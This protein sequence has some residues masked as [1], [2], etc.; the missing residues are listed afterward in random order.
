MTERLVLIL[1]LT[2]L[3]ALSPGCSG[4]MMPEH[5]DAPRAV[6]LSMPVGG[7][8]LSSADPGVFADKEDAFR[9]SAFLSD[10]DGEPSDWTATTTAQEFE[11]EP[12]D[13]VGGIPRCRVP[14]YY[15]P[16]TVGK[17]LWFY[18]YAPAAGGTYNRG[19]GAFAPT[20]SYTLTGQEDIMAAEVTGNGIAGAPYGAP[21]PQP[22]FR[23]RHLLTRLTFRLVM[24]EGFASDI[25]AS[26]IGIACC[27]NKAT[28]DIATGTLTFEG[29]PTATL[30]VKGTWAV[31]PDGEALELPNVSLMCEPGRE[32][33]VEAVVAGVTYR[34]PV[35]LGGSD[36]GTAAAGVSYLLT[37][38][39]KGTKVEAS[40][41]IVPWD[42]VGGASGEIK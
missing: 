6:S 18:A 37:L 40:G 21:Q 24:G 35:T 4:D 15:P 13:I 8:S 19:S 33:T 12:V 29:E 28:L 36:T 26:A 22:S 34:A 27:R 5:D 20:V 11:N 9:L 31:K 16:S 25:N 41:S 23:F 1:T 10:S 39:F 38:T 7:N 3:T 14:K 30:E 42:D 32:L 17:K 2:A